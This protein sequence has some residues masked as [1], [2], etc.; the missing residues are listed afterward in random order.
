MKNLKKKLQKR[1]QRRSR[2]KNN[3]N[4]NFLIIQNNKIYYCLVK[5]QATTP[6]TIINK[7]LPANLEELKKP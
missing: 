4:K 1:N 6:A 5:T 3:L 7:K 2:R